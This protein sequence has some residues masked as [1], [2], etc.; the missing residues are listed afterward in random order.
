MTHT[1]KIEEAASKIFDKLVEDRTGIPNIT[2]LIGYEAAVKLALAL[3]AAP[4]KERVVYLPKTEPYNPDHWRKWT[5]PHTPEIW[6]GTMGGVVPNSAASA[7]LHPE[8]P[9]QG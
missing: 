6:C 2:A 3:Q 8:R 4:I 9:T 1:T 7:K 5:S